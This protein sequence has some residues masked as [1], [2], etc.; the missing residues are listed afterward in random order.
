MADAGFSPVVGGGA[1]TDP[2]RPPL[3]ALWW[4]VVLWAGVIF[5]L[6]SF[7]S[8]PSPPTVS[9][10]H[11]HMAVYGLLAALIVR[12]LAGGRLSGVTWR[13]A[14]LAIGLATVYGVTDELHQ[15]FVPGREP[16]VLDV[17]ADAAGAALAA[18]ALRAW[19]IIRPRR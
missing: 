4:P 8:L 16:S 1:G 3:W 10:K 6:S 17:V 13:A 9:D 11:S 2:P 19:A 15:G 18:V 12:A 5:T 7:P 14:G